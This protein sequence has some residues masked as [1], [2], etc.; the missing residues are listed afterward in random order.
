ML[1]EYG[2]KDLSMTIENTQF[3]G[4]NASSFGGGLVGTAHTLDYMFCI[5][6]T[7]FNII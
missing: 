5:I 2:Y 1:V 6:I 3:I 4:N 7:K